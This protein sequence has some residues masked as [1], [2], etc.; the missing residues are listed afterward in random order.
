MEKAYRDALYV[1]PSYGETLIIE[2][3]FP[4]IDLILKKVGVREICILTADNPG[5]HIKTKAENKRAYDE[6]C[7][8]VEKDHFRF[9]EGV[10]KDPQG[11]FPDEVSIWVFGM[12]ESKGKRI[13][14]QFGQNA[15]VYYRIGESA[16]LVWCK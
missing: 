7:K 9:V 13:G 14:K 1:C 12:D 3:S 11:K 8:R 4:S 5:S 10:N 16:R 2:E 15:F 6:M